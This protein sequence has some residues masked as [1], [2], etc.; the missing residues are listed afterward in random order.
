MT[1]LVPY[2]RPPRHLA[3]PGEA[4]L[5]ACVAAAGPAARF[6]WDEFFAGALA[7]PHTRRAYARAAADFFAWLAPTGVALLDV[8]PGLVGRYFRQHPGSVPSRKL[9][10]A[11]LRALFDVLVQRHVLLLNPAA[12]V[13]GEKH[14]VVEGKTPEITVPQARALLASVDTGTLVGKRDKA[15]LGV[16]AYT[17]ARVGAVARLRRGDLQFDGG[18]WV[19]RFDR[20][21]GGKSRE[22]PVR[23]DLQELILDFTRAAS[24]SDAPKDAPLFPSAAGRTGQLTGSPLSGADIYR[25]VKRRLE[26]A[27]LPGR[28]SPHSFRVAAITDLLTQG[29]PLEDVQYLVGHADPRTTRLYDRRRQRVSRNVVERISI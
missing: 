14:Q 22:I 1:A 4:A 24:L 29:V 20:E 2:D 19:L 3:L 17:A 16:L 23:H 11:A 21:K 18:Q 27:G 25:L 12:S 10:L 5:P 26:A 6:A 15:I 7:N 8:T 13:R 9:A 28:L